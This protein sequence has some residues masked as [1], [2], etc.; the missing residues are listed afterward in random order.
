MMRNLFQRSMPVLPVPDVKVAAAFW[1]DKLGFNVRGEW[2]DP[3]CFAIVGRDLITVG[4]D[5]PESATYDVSS[6]WSAYLYVENVDDFASELEA[7]GVSLLWP[8]DDAP[9]GC[10][11]FTIEA[12][13]GHKIAFG[14]DLSPGVAG[15]GL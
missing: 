12:P 14:T 7:R 13:G 3:P 1:R 6:G 8:V 4:L 9:Y 10:R 15:P 11:D 5:L 2:G